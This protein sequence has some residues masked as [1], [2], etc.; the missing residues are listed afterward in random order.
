MSK[1]NFVERWMRL[2]NRSINLAN[3]LLEL[4]VEKQIIIELNINVID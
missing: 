2:Q 1:N 4:A 3:A